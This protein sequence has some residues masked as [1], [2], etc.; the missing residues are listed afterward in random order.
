MGRASPMTCKLVAIKPLEETTKPAPTP[1]SL[2]SRP[3]WEMTTTEGRASWARISTDLSWDAAMGVS[4]LALD[5]LGFLSAA[6]SRRGSK[7]A[8]PAKLLQPSERRDHRQ[9]LHS[10]EAREG[11]RLAPRSQRSEY[12]SAKVLAQQCEK[13]F[14]CAATG[15]R[16]RATGTA[17]FKKFTPRNC[18]NQS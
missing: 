6:K 1:S 8:R 5:F 10:R 11:A 4:I 15:D 7:Q 2:P 18:D 9:A 13:Y 12:R 16:S 3:K 14:A 17:V